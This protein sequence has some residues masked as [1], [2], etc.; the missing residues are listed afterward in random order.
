M[1]EWL[2]EGLNGWMGRLGRRL[3]GWRD[4]WA[5]GWLDGGE[6]KERGIDG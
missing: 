4:T 2:G 1:D 3:K 5:E 6:G